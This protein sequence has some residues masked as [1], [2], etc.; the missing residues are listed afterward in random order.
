[1]RWGGEAVGPGRKCYGTGSQSPQAACAPLPG[2]EGPDGICRDLC[3]QKRAWPGSGEVAGP[4]KGERPPSR[5]RALAAW[6]QAS[7]WGR[8]SG[9]HPVSPAHPSPVMASGTDII[10]KLRLEIERCPP[11]PDSQPLFPC[12]PPHPVV[13]SS[14]HR[15]PFLSLRKT[16]LQI[17]SDQLL[18]R[19]RLFATP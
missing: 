19:V 7:S 14:L 15:P 5:S 2:K 3:Q 8:R 18:S 1:M 11:Q 4:A 17:R 9:P 10:G 13:I 12:P 16:K 6:R